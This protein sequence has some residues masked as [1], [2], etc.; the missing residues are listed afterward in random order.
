MF[1]SGVVSL[2]VLVRPS[3]VP[4]FVRGPVDGVRLWSWSWFSWFFVSFFE[5]PIFIAQSHE[6]RSSSVYLFVVSGKQCN[7]VQTQSRL[8]VET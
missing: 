3:C 1:A 2:D 7:E 4:V 5:V 6:M 8:K